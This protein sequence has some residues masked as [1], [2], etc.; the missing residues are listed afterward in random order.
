MISGGSL[1]GERQGPPG[2]AAASGPEALPGSRRPLSPAAK[3]QPS[4]CRHEPVVCPSRRHTHCLI[5]AFGRVTST[6]PALLRSDARQLSNSG[7][8]GV[9]CR[10]APGLLLSLSGYHTPR[11]E[12]IPLSAGKSPSAPKHLDSKADGGFGKDR[13]VSGGLSEIPD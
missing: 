2:K 5:S 8:P 3:K 6:R 10:S 12:Q 13:R 7:F 9:W 1:Q 4:T 11:C